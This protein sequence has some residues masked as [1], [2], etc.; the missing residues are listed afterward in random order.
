M[1]STRS[2]S[3]T[4][5]VLRVLLV[6]NPILG[7]AILVLLVASVLYEDWVFHALTHMPPDAIRAMASGLRV[8]MVIGIVAVPLNHVIL[9][10]LEV[11]VATVQGGD[12]FLAANA[13]RL[14]AIAWALLGLQILNLIASSMGGIDVEI[15]RAHV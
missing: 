9:T 3:L 15:G 1:S 8:V 5:T 11:M 12:P 4:R 14:R 10:R 7:V 2:L 13:A 6:I